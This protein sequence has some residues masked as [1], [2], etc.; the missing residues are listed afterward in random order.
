MYSRDKE[1]QSGGYGWIYSEEQEPGLP[2]TLAEQCKL[3]GTYRQCQ[4]AIGS[5]A[6]VLSVEMRAREMKTAPEKRQ[7]K[8]GIVAHIRNPRTQEAMEVN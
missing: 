6:L 3:I 7:E 5:R 4:T 1:Q 2:A 8:P